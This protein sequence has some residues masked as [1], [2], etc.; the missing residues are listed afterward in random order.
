ML[1]FN[2]NSKTKAMIGK[3]YLDFNKFNQKN[4]ISVKKLQIRAKGLI[5]SYTEADQAN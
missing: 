4:E 3:F 5:G 2:P 1:M